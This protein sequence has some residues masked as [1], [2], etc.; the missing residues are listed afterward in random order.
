MSQYLANENFPLASANLL[1]EAGLAVAIVAKETP[2]ASDTA[3]LERAA[4]ERRIVLTFDRDYGD[5]IF[6][7][8]QTVPAGVIYFRYDPSAPEE[9]AEHVLRLMGVEELSFEGK[10][11]VLE[12]G[13]VRQRPLP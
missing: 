6:R 5:L 1:R 13:H 9:P 8:R 4:H 7:R 2:G 3:I 10:F 12:R 11:T